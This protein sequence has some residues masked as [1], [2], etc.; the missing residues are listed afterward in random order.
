MQIFMYILITV[1]ITKRET[2]ALP[3]CKSYAEREKEK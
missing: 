1:I 2:C 3:L